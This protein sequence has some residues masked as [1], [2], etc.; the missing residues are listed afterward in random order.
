M[1]LLTGLL[2]GVGALPPCCGMVIAHSAGLPGSSGR[3]NAWSPL[4]SRHPN[5]R[6][7]VESR[8]PPA[9]RRSRRRPRG[10]CPASPTPSSGP[11]RG[12]R[13]ARAP[14]AAPLGRAGGRRVG[15]ARGPSLG[16]A[17]RGRRPARRRCGGHHRDRPAGRRRHGV[18]Q[19]ALRVAAEIGPLQRPGRGHRCR[20]WPG[21]T[22]SP[23][24][25][26]CRATSWA[27]RGRGGRPAGVARPAA[28]RADPRRRWSSRRSCTPSWP[29]WVPSPVGAGVVARAAGRLALVTRGW[30]RRRCRYPRWATSS[31][32]GRRTSRRWP[33]TRRRRRRHRRLGRA[34]RRGRGA[35]CP[36]RRRGLRVDPARRLT[37]ACAPA[38]Q[39]GAPEGGRR[40]GHVRPGYQACTVRRETR[41]SLARRPVH[42][43]VAAWVPSCR[44]S[45][46]GVTHRRR[47]GVRAGRPSLLPPRGHCGVSRDRHARAGGGPRLLRR[48]ARAT[49]APAVAAPAP[50]AAAASVLG[51]GRRTPANRSRSRTGVVKTSTGQSRASGLPAQRP[52]RVDRVRVADRLEHRQVGHRVAVGVAARQVVALGLGQLADRLGLGRRRRRSTRSRRCSGRPRPPS[53]WRSRG[54]RRASRRSARRPRR[55]TSTITTSRPAAWCSSMRSAAS[56]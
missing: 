36:R 21:C 10:H 53:G 45:P 38:A 26:R 35:R 23:P 43:Q 22:C 41:T 47:L 46:T 54:R 11:P 12:R 19:G 17:G 15:A 40:L 18:V 13:P 34:L 1:L 4:R 48:R 39:S 55:R 32:A 51:C 30:T 29:R 6:P 24:P 8:D 44:A 28:D 42:G 49:R 52:V 7:I 3:V 25:V 50:T 27:A 2:E 16:G 9:D 56:S 37:Y 20:C 31:W 5:G 33:A 14:G